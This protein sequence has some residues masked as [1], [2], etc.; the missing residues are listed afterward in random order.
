MTE[1][2]LET[3]AKTS[4]GTSDGTSFIHTNNGNESLALWAKACATALPCL[5][6]WEKEK[7]LMEWT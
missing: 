2:Y 7:L 4:D 6:I 3:K 5:T 1:K